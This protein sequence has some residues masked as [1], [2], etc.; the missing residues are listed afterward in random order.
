MRVLVLVAAL[1]LSAD[2]AVLTRAQRS[3]LA[4][5]GGGAK[6]PPTPSVMKMNDAWSGTA[7]DMALG[8]AVGAACGYTVGSSVKL[9]TTATI[10]L[11]SYLISQ[12]TFAFALS[13]LAANLGLVTIHWERVGILGWK[14][15]R[16]ADADKDGKLTKADLC[17]GLGK[18]MPPA[19]REKLWATLDV[20]GD[21]VITSKDAELL[22]KSNQHAGAGGAV[23]FFLGLAKG[24]GLA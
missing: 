8:G 16:F 23:G 24:L 21:G 10:G 7:V 13:R 11:S 17:L 18:I 19:L 3:V 5:R 12:C 15:F 9:A 14:L 20:D 6:P 1:T 4:L 22:S 2:A